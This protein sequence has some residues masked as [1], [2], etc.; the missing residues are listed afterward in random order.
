MQ[1]YTKF[2]LNKMLKMRYSGVVLITIFLSVLQAGTSNGLEETSMLA[3]SPDQKSK[4]AI[5]ENM[6]D[7]KKS[8]DATKWY[9]VTKNTCI[10]F[11]S[12]A[13]NDCI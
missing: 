9:N 10:F 13:L 5:N 1:P 7:G 12:D 3:L 2:P 11:F 8:Y 6:L 4:L